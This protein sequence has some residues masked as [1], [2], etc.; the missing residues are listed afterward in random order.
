MS[1]CMEYQG[2]NACTRYSVGLTAHKANIVGDERDIVLRFKTRMSR[3]F[4]DHISRPHGFHMGTD[5]W[6][7]GV[8]GNMR[9]TTKARKIFSGQ[10]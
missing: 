9:K 5:E 8:Y 3:L 4:E 10:M 2:Q 6:H 7:W 1:K